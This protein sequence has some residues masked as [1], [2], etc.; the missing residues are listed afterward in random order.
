MSRITLTN[1]DGT[2]TVECECGPTADDV[3]EALLIPVL[4]AAGYSESTIKGLFADGVTE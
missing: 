2:Y 1:E 3:A 4:R